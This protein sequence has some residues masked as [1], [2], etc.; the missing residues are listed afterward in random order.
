M[1]RANYFWAAGIVLV[2]LSCV[3]SGYVDKFDTCR[4]L[5]LGIIDGNKTYG[6]IDN[7]TIWER[8]YIYSGGIRGLDPS[9]PRADIL[10]LTYDGKHRS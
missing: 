2:I 4:H 7:I 5:V 8:P 1:A 9:Y 10:T 3:A 6:D